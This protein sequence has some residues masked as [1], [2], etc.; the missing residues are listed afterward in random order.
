MDIRGV[1]L[2]DKYKYICSKPHI[3]IVMT[4]L[5]TVK[6]IYQSSH[7]EHNRAVEPRSA[8]DNVD[9]MLKYQSLL[10]TSAG[11][12]ISSCVGGL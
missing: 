9:L 10:F 7:S 1:N 4:L 6:M 2:I 11:C 5:L 12:V 8:C 3:D